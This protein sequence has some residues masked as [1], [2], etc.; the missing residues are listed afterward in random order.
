MIERLMREWDGEYV[1]MRYD[2]AADAW[3]FIAIHSTRLG[4]ALG[5]T[6]MKAYDSPA[7]AL[8]DAQRL[9]EGMTYKWAGID[10]PQG[11]GKAV[12]ALTRDVSEKE[13]EELLE[14]Y[15][16]LVEALQGQFGTGLDLGI[17][18]E[19]ILV[20]ARK[21]RY[22]HGAREDS[23]GDPG[24]WTA[25]GVFSGMQAV[26]AELFGDADPKD[27]TVLI[28]G[29]GD[30]G[31]PLAELLSE[32]GARLK[33][34]DL[35][36]ARVRDA[37]HRFDADVVDPG[38]VYEEPCDIFAPCAVGAV[39]NAD[40]IPRLGCKAVAG[41]ANNQLDTRED[42][43]RMHERGILYSPD[44]IINAGGAIAL[45]GVEARGMSQAEARERIVAIGDTLK[46]LF[47]EA[48]ERNESPLLA[49]ERRARRVLERG[50]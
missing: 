35:N 21:T 50:P 49:A 8:K 36:E 48:R 20:I 46:A 7:D 47:E 12:I 37:A 1:V 9:S 31:L 13:R 40:S 24:P 27:R 10:F 6:R 18:P 3:I 29:V 15:G 38:A 28:Q 25:L 4:S 43:G 14:R 34:S 44:Y 30:V 5:G 2:H 22:V 33:L 16:A 11:G 23:P 26:L 42:A 41:S 17:T 32:A 39:L 19:D 45:N